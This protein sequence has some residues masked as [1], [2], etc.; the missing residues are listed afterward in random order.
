MSNSNRLPPLP[1]PSAPFSAS[2]AALDRQ[3]AVPPLTGRVYMQ[4]RVPHYTQGGAQPHG[5]QSHTYSAQQQ[6]QLIRITKLN[7]EKKSMEFDLQQGSPNLIKDN[8]QLVMPYL[9]NILSQYGA[10]TNLLAGYDLQNIQLVDRSEKKFYI[11][12]RSL[13]NNNLDYALA[14]TLEKKGNHPYQ[15][16][17]SVKSASTIIYPNMPR[18]NLSSHNPSGLAPELEGWRRTNQVDG[19]LNILGGF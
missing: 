17:P 16:R 18:T 12:L 6:A 1:P 14:L 5:Q 10:H 9:Q 11:I 7:A 3:A 13:S 4:S 19:F 8:Q 2:Q 15:I